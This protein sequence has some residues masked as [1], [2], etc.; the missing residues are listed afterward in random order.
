MRR[1]DCC[2]LCDSPYSHKHPRHRS[3]HHIF[4]RT[5]Y[6]NSTLTVE[7]CWKCHD[8][9]NRKFMNNARG[10]WSNVEC[11]R[12]WIS[13]CYLKGKVATRIY[14]QLLKYV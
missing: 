6:P 9:F 11:V 7:V 13:F 2:P 12:F 3:T 14:P 1:V 10:R 5:W 8:E 4:P